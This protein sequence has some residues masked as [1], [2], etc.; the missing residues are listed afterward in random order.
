MTSV[1]LKAIQERN[2]R[3]QGSI[4]VFFGLAQLGH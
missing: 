1:M 4:T 3:P 2:L